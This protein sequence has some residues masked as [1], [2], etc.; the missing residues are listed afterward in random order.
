MNLYYKITTLKRRGKTINLPLVACVESK[1]FTLTDGSIIDNPSE[2]QIMQAGYALI[3]LPE[4]PTRV[5]AGEEWRLELNFSGDKV[6]PIYKSQK[7]NKQDN[8][9]K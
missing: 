2:E 7:I 3:A 5:I 1:S 8:E 4:K 9:N 6:S